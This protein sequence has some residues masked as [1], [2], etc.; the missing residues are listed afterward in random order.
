MG[1]LHYL[2]LA[3]IQTNATE[4]NTAKVSNSTE[5]QNALNNSNISVI[6]LTADIDLGQSGMGNLLIPPRDL[7]IDGAVSIRLT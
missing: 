2:M 7:T 4:E 6:R 5:F 3:F 1:Q